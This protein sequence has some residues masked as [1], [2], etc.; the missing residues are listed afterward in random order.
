MLRESP[1]QRPNIYQV[2]A[3]TCAMRHRACPIKDVCIANSTRRFELTLPRSTLAGRNLK[4]AET[5][6][7]RLQN[8]KYP[9]RHR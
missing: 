1:Q 5:S 2:V 7:C 6:S 8:L 4:L 3:E 9:R